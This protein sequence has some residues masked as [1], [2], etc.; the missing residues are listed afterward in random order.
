MGFLGSFLT[1]DVLDEAELQRAQAEGVVLHLRRLK[2]SIAYDR[3]RAPGKRFDGKRVRS[4][5]G[6]LVTTPRIVLWAGGVRQLDLDRASL[7]SPS[8]SVTADAETVEVAWAAE[9]FH[10]DRSGS[11]RVKL[12]TPEA[13]R[14][15]ELLAR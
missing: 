2:A 10:P 12:W 13:R 8:L 11:V 4:S 6:V 9:N 3:Y 14:V 15:E 1:G 5:G 7:P